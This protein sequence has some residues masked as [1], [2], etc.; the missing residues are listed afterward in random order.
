MRKVLPTL[1]KVGKPKA[2]ATTQYNNNKQTNNES[3][4]TQ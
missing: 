4:V 1:D 3:E 2:K